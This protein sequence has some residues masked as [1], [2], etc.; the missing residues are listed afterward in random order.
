MKGFK[1][2]KI[3][4]S[5]IELN[6]FT[7]GTG[8]PMLLLHG[9]PQNHLAWEA[10]GQILSNSFTVIIPDLRGY[11]DSSPAP[12]DENHINYS[13][14]EMGKDFIELMN[15]FDFDEFYIAGH[16]RGGRVAYRMALDYSNR[17]KKLILLDIIPTGEKINIINSQ[18]AYASYH[19]FFLSQPFDLPEKLIGSNSDYYITHLIERWIGKGNKLNS[20][21]LKEYKR[22]FRKESVLRSM[23]EDYRAGIFVDA[24]NDLEDLKKGNKIKCPTLIIWG[25]QET[26]GRKIEWIDYWKK[27]AIS[28][29]G[30]PISCGHFIMEEEPHLTSE[31]IIKFIKEDNINE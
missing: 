24:P 2:H 29:Q 18:Q 15:Y 6:V 30:V 10:A 27:W 9:F 12:F 5:K 3:R 20:Y 14:R 23:C 1:N 22:H 28:I 4:L 25:Q 11:G 21:N 26:E 17:I 16:D 7:K 13:K 19:W 31:A 8:E